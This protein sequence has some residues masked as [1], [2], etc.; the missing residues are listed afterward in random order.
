MKPDETPKN[1]CTPEISKAAHAFFTR[2]H[3]ALGYSAESSLRYVTYIGH[4]EV[5]LWVKV[6]HKEITRLVAVPLSV[7]LSEDE[8]R[9]TDWLVERKKK[10]RQEQRKRDYSWAMDFCKDIRY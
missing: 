1:I 2:H 9:Q 7:L 8:N 3:Y 6:P 4:D 10:E 5:Y